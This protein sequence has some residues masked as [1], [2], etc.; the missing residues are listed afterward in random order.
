MLCRGAAPPPAEPLRQLFAE[1]DACV[2][3]QGPWRAAGDITLSFSLRRDGT[4]IGRP[5]VAFFRAPPGESDR[6][7][8]IEDAASALGRCLP[9][10]LTEGL[11]GAIAGRPLTFRLKINGGE[12]AI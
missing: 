12:R 1:I 6:Q 7:A 11:G 10:R 8:L 9:A 2:S 3:Q 4:L 5:H